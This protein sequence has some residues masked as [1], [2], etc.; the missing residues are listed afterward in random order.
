MSQ[1]EVNK[2]RMESM[3]PQSAARTVAIPAKHDDLFLNPA[4]GAS[5]F[6]FDQTTASVFDD[7]VG[8]SVPFYDEIQRMTGEI[9]ADFAV[10]N[11][12]LFDLG[13]STGTTLACLD[14]VV[15]S[16]VRFI[17]VD[18]SP[19]MLDRARAKL[20]HLRPSRMVQLIRAD[21][22]DDAIISNASVVVMNLTLQFVRPMYR[23]SVIRWIHDGLNPQGC[24]ILIE[25]QTMPDSLLNRLFIRYYY[26]FKRRN[27]Y[28]EME[29]AHK[30]EALEN[31][32]IPYRPDENRAMLKSIGFTYVEETFRWYN[33]AGML[34]V[35]S[36]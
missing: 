2:P 7:M 1:D 23:E 3:A 36:G 14:K 25:K 13:C 12:N 5:D 22:H 21:L 34:A 28:S 32:L 20:E 27:G 18:N 15:R 31:V 16:G 35:K 11:T 26:D 9:A 10:E 17:G 19:E 4:S 8:R 24:L 30:R 6:R 29:I 33:F